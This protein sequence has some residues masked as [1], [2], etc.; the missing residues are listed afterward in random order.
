[1]AQHQ[2]VD[3]METCLVSFHPENPTQ[4]EF[5]RKVTE[6][7]AVYVTKLTPLMRAREETVS[8]VNINRLMSAIT[9]F[10]CESQGFVALRLGRFVAES[11]ERALFF[12]FYLCP[13]FQIVD[14]CPRV[15]SP[16]DHRYHLRHEGGD[17]DMGSGDAW[18][19]FPVGVVLAGLKALLEQLE[20]DI[21]F[22]EANVQLDAELSALSK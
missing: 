5:A 13:L 20:T 10:N 9:D 3:P 11:G 19:E 7:V 17:K 21:P 16:H 12:D 4:E 2:V 15:P 14:I 22:A 6:V 1:M 8:S 18:K